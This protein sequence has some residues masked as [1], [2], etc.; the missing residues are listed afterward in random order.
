MFSWHIIKEKGK[1]KTEGK[2]GKFNIKMKVL[3]IFIALTVS[4]L[5]ER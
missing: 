3:S 2:G 5:I 1:G 4:V